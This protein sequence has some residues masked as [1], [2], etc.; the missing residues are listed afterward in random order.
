M[1]SQRSNLHVAITGLSSDIKYLYVTRVH[2]KMVRTESE[3]RRRRKDGKSYKKGT[4]KKKVCRA[5]FVPCLNAYRPIDAQQYVLCMNNF[6]WKLFFDFPENFFR[7]FFF[8][9]LFI[10]FPTNF[11]CDGF[12]LGL[13]FSVCITLKI[14]PNSIGLF[15]R[16]I[17][18]VRIVR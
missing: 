2:V 6:R 17:C 8:F 15:A 7:F 5:E 3:E 4:Q 14:H 11:W 10:S 12:R 9:V 16:W 1:S 18:S 13:F